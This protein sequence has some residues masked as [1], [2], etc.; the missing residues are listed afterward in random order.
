MHYKNGRE[1]KEGDHAI[2]KIWRGG[3]E[4]PTVGVLHSLN[5]GAQS[6]NGQLAYAVPG[7]TNTACVTIGELYHAEDA[8][9]ACK[10]SYV[11]GAEASALPEDQ[12]T[13]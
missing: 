7:G 8:L 13:P 6:C 4:V 2:G 5:A 10:Y 3:N 9:A 11:D 12:A 1:A